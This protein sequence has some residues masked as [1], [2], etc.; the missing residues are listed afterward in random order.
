M[1]L[2]ITALLRLAELFVTSDLIVAMSFLAA[3]ARIFFSIKSR[4]ICELENYDGLNLE[5]RN[6]RQLVP[7]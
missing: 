7:H 6:P 3:A 1:L 4:P 5:L 2:W